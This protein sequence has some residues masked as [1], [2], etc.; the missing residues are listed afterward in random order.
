LQR[1]LLLRILSPGLSGVKRRMRYDDELQSLRHELDDLLNRAARMKNQIAAI[2]RDLRLESIAK[3]QAA[4]HPPEDA[5]PS[6]PVSQS[7][8][9]PP[10]LPVTDDHGP[11]IEPVPVPIPVAS[12]TFASTHEEPALPKVSQSSR[13]LAQPPAGIEARIGMYWLLRI[14]SVLLA[15][16]V[17]WTLYYISP[18]TTPLMRV[19]FGYGVAAVV[20]FA[21]WR[22]EKKY[23]PYA[24]VL[25]ASGIGISYF[26]TFAAHYIDAAR[27]IY[28]ETAGIVALL[29]VVT[30]WGVVAQ[31]RRSR[32]VATLVTLLGHLTMALAFLTDGELARLSIVGIAVLGLGS[33]FFLLANRWYYV[34]VVGMIG[35]YINHTLWFVNLAPTTEQ[36]DFNLTF[37][38]LCVYMLTFALAELLSPEDLRRS[39][40]PTKYRTLFVSANSAF[41]FLLGT[42]AFHKY[43]HM[44][45]YRDVVLATYA[46]VLGLIGL[47]YLRLRKGDPL[48]NV[49]LTK[50]V[51]VFTLA[52][53]VRYGQGTLTASL[54]IQAVVLLYSARRS[55]LVVTRVLAFAVAALCVLQALYGWIDVW[56]VRYDNP[57]HSRRI[58]EAMFA[59][60]GLFVASQLYQRTDWSQRSPATLPVSPDTLGLFWKLDLVS[61]PP[62]NRVT[63]EKPFDGLLFPYLYALGGLILVC[64]YSMILAGNAHRVGPLAL[65]VLLATIGAYVLRARPLGLVAM[66]ALAPTL[67]SAFVANVVA[68]NAPVW[69]IWA[70]TT[71]VMAAS[72]LGDRRIAGA[73]EGL[74]FHQMRPSPYFLYCTTA[75]MLV[76]ALLA[77]TESSLHGALY[78]AIAAAAAAILTTL[79]HA[80]AL[81]TSSIVLLGFAVIGWSVH[82]DD[83]AT[84]QWHAIVLIGLGV[85]IFID[86]FYARKVT[87]ESLAPWGAAALAFGWFLVM[88]YVAALGKDAW[89]FNDVPG[90]ATEGFGYYADDWQ[91]F[92]AA[93]VSFAYA[94]YAAFTRSRTAVT[95]AGIGALFGSLEIINDSY[96]RELSTLAIICGYISLA[97]FWAICER[98]IVRIKTPRF[99][100]FLQPLC[101]VAVGFASILLVVMVER[102]PTLKEYFLTVGWGLLA[103]V[104]FAVSLITAQRF[105]RY[106]GLGVFLL[107]ILRLF[108]DAY[109]LTGV[110]RPLA[111][112]GLATLMFVVS[113]GY[114]YAARLLDTRKPDAPPPSQPPNLPQPENQRKE[115]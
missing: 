17:V 112:I 82:S 41:F 71:M 53:A 68:D 64:L 55:G 113:F 3:E 73:N 32:I 58:V 24:R 105:Y 10:P 42:A 25:Y 115:E 83:S 88:R 2:E 91:P 45:Q 65:F 90:P 46:V 60:A 15:I 84:T 93:L 31:V 104:L 100:P 78:L 66:L 85:S 8:G 6:K 9:M 16:G 92:A 36:A 97:V 103:I 48:Y 95:V 62:R 22:L 43:D 114:Y 111:F 57:E 70:T 86:R 52:L 110:Y 98:L 75:L 1:T 61:E 96:Q 35:C 19:G 23:L 12:P 81:A 74:A 39:L 54:A 7:P 69:L 94:G 37:G 79:L 44:L 63:R 102:I 30:L 72:V 18:H 29:G 80:R 76:I 21:G 14:A 4:P 59:V 51:S 106:A 5:P 26:V 40:V 109:E 101:G 50:A 108:K 28:S 77:R 11:L 38:F 67:A 33:A 56:T 89:W 107:A 13:K 49:Y 87:A 47:G 27:I 34:A 20:L 99:Q